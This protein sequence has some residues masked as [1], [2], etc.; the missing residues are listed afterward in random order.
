[1]KIN[2]DSPELLSWLDRWRGLIAA[3]W[4]ARGYSHH[5]PTISV[6]ETK[7]PNRL[8]VLYDKTSVGAFIDRDTGDIL[9]PKNF[10][11]PAKHARGNLFAE[12]GGRGAIASAYGIRTLK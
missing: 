10:T 2:L 8:R 5:M 6:E 11:S 1:M 12:D 9:Y 3:E 4:Q 7:V